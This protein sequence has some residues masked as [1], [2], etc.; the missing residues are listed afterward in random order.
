MDNI[1]RRL[2]SY[3]YRNPNPIN[4]SDR[5][6]ESRQD[7][8]GS[9]IL[10]NSQR[11]PIVRSLNFSNLDAQLRRGNIPIDLIEDFLARVPKNLNPKELD[12]IKSLFAI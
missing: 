5:N 7:N 4:R 11:V 12:Q 9:Y 8:R 3:T 6:Q 10:S 2:N 1:N